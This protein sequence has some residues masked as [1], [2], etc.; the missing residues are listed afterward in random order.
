MIATK[1][2]SEQ[3]D[4]TANRLTWPIREARPASPKLQR[5]SSD[6]S[7]TAPKTER[8]GLDDA[9]SLVM[10]CGLAG[11]MLVLTTGMARGVLNQFT[12]H[13]SLDLLRML[14]GM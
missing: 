3:R 2:R 1:T 14:S 13:N 4:S 8:G 9:I 7:K 5:K 12:Q 11:L 10:L 6:A